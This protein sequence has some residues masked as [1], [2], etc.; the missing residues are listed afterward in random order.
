MKLLGI[1]PQQNTT[2]HEPCTNSDER[3]WYNGTQI[4]PYPAGHTTLQWGH[5]ERD[6][7]SNHKPHDCLLNRL[8]MRRWEKNI[9][10][11]RHWPLCG[12]FT[13]DRWITR[14]KGQ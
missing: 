7:V 1:K 13:G 10:A 9:K 8:L 2:K 3:F 4:G 14:K 11:P 5:N 6:G 12:E